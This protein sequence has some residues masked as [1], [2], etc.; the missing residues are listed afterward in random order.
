M[1]APTVDE[2]RLQ[3]S[4]RLAPRIKRLD[5][6]APRSFVGRL[7]SWVDGLL[8]NP[9]TSSADGMGEHAIVD[10]A[11]ESLLRGNLAT[12]IERLTELKGMSAVIMTEW[13]KD[14]KARLEMDRAGADLM[15]KSF[16]RM[17]RGK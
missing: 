3:F 7:G 12:A 1:G 5:T 2:L 6:D 9:T 11:Q 17:A 16:D 8:D 10:L 4:E 15:A 14:A 13:M